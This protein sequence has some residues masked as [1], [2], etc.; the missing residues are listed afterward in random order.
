MTAVAKVKNDPVYKVY[1]MGRKK[2]LPK[3]RELL[4]V[5]GVDLSRSGISASSVAVQDFG[6]FGSVT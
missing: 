5:T 3:V 2:I 4:R 6:I 1:K